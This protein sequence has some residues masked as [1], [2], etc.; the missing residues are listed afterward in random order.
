MTSASNTSNTQVC[1][2]CWARSSEGQRSHRT[3]LRQ[4]WGDLDLHTTDVPVVINRPS[5]LSGNSGV[6]VSSAELPATSYGTQSGG[7]Q[8][9][10]PM[11]VRWKPSGNRT[12]DRWA[13]A[14]SRAASRSSPSPTT[15]STRPPEATS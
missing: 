11:S 15:P 3:A 9:G 5:F 10:T 8:W 4:G 7:I 2:G 13:Y 14:R 1:W 12:W 6:S